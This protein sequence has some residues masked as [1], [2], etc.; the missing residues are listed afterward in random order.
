MIFKRIR[1]ILRKLFRRGGLVDLL[2]RF[3]EEQGR[4]C[5]WTEGTAAVFVAL[6]KNLREFRPGLSVEDI[7]E[8][9]LLDLLQFFVDQGY[10]NTTIDKKLSLLKWFLRWCAEK[11]HYSGNAHLT[12]AP[13]L[14]GGHYEDKEVVYL[15]EE[16][17][18]RLEH[19]SF[20]PGSDHDR[21]RDL[22]VF[23]CY[24]GLR[25]S[26]VMALRK[27][28][29]HDG[30]I[31][32][33]TKKT[34]KPVVIHTN[35]HTERII[36]KYGG[37]EGER[38]LPTMVSQVVNRKLK[39]IGRLAGIDS[40]VRLVRHCGSQTTVDYRP[41][42]EVLSFHV[43]RRTFVTMAVAKGI[44]SQVIMAWT[45]HKSERMLRPYLA[46]VDSVKQESM[47]L[48]DQ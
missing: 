22:F 17:L 1:H 41:K 44:P 11:G 24:C 20:P 10:S 18:R 26:D 16:E 2:S 15:T 37:L 23:A 29:I 36:R 14:K 30:A 8:P 12:F 21:V 7:D 33:V 3:V 31:H 42:H 40:P 35:S 5:S 45:G 25:F 13:R 46:V 48:F 19:W 27:H 32:V 38:L 6:G 4:L 47:R 28:D 43:A 34:G 9:L 39:D